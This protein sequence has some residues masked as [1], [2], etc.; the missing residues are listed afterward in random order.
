M[1]EENEVTISQ[2]SFK[3]T[4]RLT[5]IMVPKQYQALNYLHMY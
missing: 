4:M 5:T 2:Q 3:E 1:K